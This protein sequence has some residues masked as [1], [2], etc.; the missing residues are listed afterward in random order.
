MDDELAR[1]AE[2]LRTVPALPGRSHPFNEESHGFRLNPPAAEVDVAAFEREHGV[3]LPAPYRRFVTEIGDGGAGPSY[4]L[5]PVAAA[6]DTVRYLTYEGFLA[7]PSPL[8]DGLG[9]DWY[10]EYLDEDLPRDP[11]DGSLAVAHF[12]CDQYTVLVVTGD[13]RGRLVTVDTAGGVE[14]YVTEDPDFLSWYERWLD[15]VAAGYSVEAF[16]AKLPGDEVALLTIM[17]GDQD[18]ARRQRA[19]WSLCCLPAL[20]AAAAS[21]LVT[22]TADPSDQVRATAL[23]T[24]AEGAIAAVEGPARRAVDT[25]T[26]ANVRAAALRVLAALAVPD[27]RQLARRLLADEHLRDQAARVLA[28]AGALTAADLAP[29]SRDPDPRARASA[30]HRLSDVTGPEVPTLLATALRDA[31]PAVRRL[32]V[33]AAGRRREQSLREAVVA[34]RDS[35]PDDLVRQNAARTLSF[36]R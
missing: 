32:A 20:P 35:D 27:L 15:E 2:K 24:A 7:V 17:T 22:A 18:A 28:D 1:I 33:Q 4:G 11:L 5:R 34:L 26:D 12:G 23:R 8:R 25:E 21:A 6:Y 13:L 31:D 9:E 30:A 3:A 10:D 36:W 16:G 19:A 29:L 14:P